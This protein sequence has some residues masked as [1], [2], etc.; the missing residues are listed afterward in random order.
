LSLN[1]ILSS[2]LSAILSNSAALRVT[3]NNI[4]NINSPGYNRRVVEMQTLAPGGQLGGVAIADVRRVLDQFLTREVLEST[5]SSSRYDAE[6]NVLARLDAALGEPGDQN[7]VIGQMNALYATLGQLSTD[8]SSMARRQA[9]LDQ[10]TTLAQSVSNLA[11]TIGDLRQ[12]ADQDV[13]QTVSQINE[14]TRKIFEINPQIQ[15]ATISGDTAS[16]LLDQRDQMVQQLSQLV[17]IKTITQADGRMFISTSDGTSL[18]GDLRSELTYVGGSATSF[19]PVMVQTISS[20]GAPLGTASVF[21]AHVASGSLRGLLDARDGSLVQAGEELGQLA[22]TLALAFNAVHNAGT[23]VP[24][25]SS[26]NGRNT[27][28]LAGDGLNFTGATTI[29]IAGQDG[30]LAHKIAIDFDAGTLSVD[31]GGAVSI[32]STVGSFTAALNTALGANGSASFTDGVMSLSAN[33]GNGFIVADDATN[34]ASRGGAGFSQFFGLNDI[35]QASGNSI[36]TTG[37]TAADAH[38]FATG[39]TMTLLLKGPMGASTK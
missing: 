29:G 14:L 9:A 22:Q 24:P 16:G 8:P 30:V 7:S 1:G 2:G 10:F 11:G 25:P 23:A 38:G 13:G 32:G 36:V 19:N 3:S 4:A 39:G 31:G 35:F 15:R 5:S 33:G 27:G 18:I 17:G 34:A 12:N 6:A 37:L 28:L 26:L 20:S 21:D